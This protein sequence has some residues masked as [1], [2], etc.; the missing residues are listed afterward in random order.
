MTLTGR[1]MN[2]SIL[3]FAGRSSPGLLMPL[4]S[5]ILNAWKNHGVVKRGDAV[6]P[7]TIFVWLTEYWTPARAE[8]LPVAI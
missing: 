6:D 1:L 4:S 2:I 3:F 8:H 7:E 5:G